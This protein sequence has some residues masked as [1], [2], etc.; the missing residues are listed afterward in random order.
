M[1]P[2]TK[3]SVHAMPKFSRDRVM[4]GQASRRYTSRYLG[5]SVAKEDSS[6]NV[7]P[8]LSAGVNASILKHCEQMPF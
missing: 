1:E 6:V 7:P 8:T 5:K 4:R 2:S 3:S